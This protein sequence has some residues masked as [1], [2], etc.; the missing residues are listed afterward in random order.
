MENNQTSI[1]FDDKT[2]AL[3]LKI[4]EDKAKKL[5]GQ[6]KKLT[7]K[8]EKL[9]KELGDV[10][11]LI[12]H[13]TGKYTPQPERST[14]PQEPSINQESGVHSGIIPSPENI[15]Q[16]NFPAIVA[17]G[18]SHNFKWPERIEYIV[19]NAPFALNRQNIL[20]Y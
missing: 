7:D 6:I 12:Q 15:V 10:N 13:I 16:D 14:T 3:S 17:P 19:K 9:E 5:S 1:T 20:L 11:V 4:Y 2:L 8:K 18:Y